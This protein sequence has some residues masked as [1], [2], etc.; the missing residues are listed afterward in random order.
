MLRLC[1]TSGDTTQ[2]SWGLR[3]ELFFS[4]IAVFLVWVIWSL[5]FGACLLFGAWDLEF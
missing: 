4:G 5:E 3:D 2:Q 1:E